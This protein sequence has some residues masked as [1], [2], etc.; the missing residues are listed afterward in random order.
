MESVGAT[1]QPRPS[2]ARLTWSG[3]QDLPT[4]LLITVISLAS[5]MARDN[6]THAQ[7]LSTVC[8]QWRAVVEETPEI[9]TQITGYDPPE[10]VNKAMEKSRD[11]SLDIRY[12]TKSHYKIQGPKAFLQAVFPHIHRWRRA[13]IVLTS[14]TYDELQGL[15]VGTAPRLESF[16]LSVSGYYGQPFTLFGGVAP[17]SLREFHVRRVSLLWG[18]EQFSN[19]KKLWIG[20]DRYW[21]LSL[22]SVLLI[23]RATLRLEEFTYRGDLS[24]TFDDGNGTISRGFILL[25][26]MKC[27]ELC[28]GS[29]GVLEILKYI[30]AP[31]CLNVSLNATLGDFVDPKISAQVYGTII[32]FLP[33]ITA[34]VEQGNRVQIKA[35]P[36]AAHFSISTV[37]FDLYHPT[38]TTK[39]L[40]WMV[41]NFA[42]ETTEMDL[43]IEDPAFSEEN[44]DLLIPPT[45][46]RRI[47]TLSIGNLWETIHRA[48]SILQYLSSPKLGSDGQVR[49]PLPHLREVADLSHSCDLLG[50]L[51]ML[52]ARAEAIDSPAVVKPLKVSKLLGE[53]PN[54]THNAS[55][56][57]E[58][59][60]V[61]AVP[62][63]LSKSQVTPSKPSTATGPE[64][65]A[66]RHISTD[67]QARLNL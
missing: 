42:D 12:R 39:V 5:E 31:A 32:Q 34:L 2:P 22:Q 55:D 58:L 54:Q 14:C 13:E 29:P 47:S 4:E 20:A 26:E 66:V 15:A 16:T 41:E 35:M 7:R 62:A 30:R 6:L 53:Q 64:S 67:T 1:D 33:R 3:I 45:L 50:I 28:S 57:L 36:Q 59:H 27:L 37:A 46:H 60:F 51:R 18:G 44:L 48:G 8:S 38:Q 25:P 61:R 56:T 11:M 10:A 52:Q 24:Q 17:G 63:L 43:T 9:W 19:L 40:K 23:L 21:P 65:D 49:W